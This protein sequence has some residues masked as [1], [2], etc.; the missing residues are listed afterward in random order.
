MSRSLPEVAGAASDGA[1]L[2]VVVTDADGTNGMASFVEPADGTPAN[3]GLVSLAGGNGRRVSHAWFDGKSFLVG[4]NDVPDGSAFATLSVRRFSTPSTPV[5]DTG[6]V[7]EPRAIS[8]FPDPVAAGDGR[9]RSLFVY[10]QDDPAHVGDAIKARLIKTD[11]SPADAGD[12]DASDG[13]GGMGAIDAGDG[14]PEARP[15]GG[16]GAM[17]S[18]PDATGGSAGSTAAGG[19]GGVAGSAGEAGSV[20]G[21][22]A[23]GTS[24]SGGTAGAGA[25]PGGTGALGGSGPRDAAAGTAGAAGTANQAAPA[26]DEGGC[27][28]HLASRTE[29]R[30][31]WVVL[32]ALGAA[33]A[34]SRRVRRRRCP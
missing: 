5:D 13:T 11:E 20:G 1:R 32:G 27:G 23:G 8:P 12:G 19:S 3:P 7:V 31:S 30:L 24:A 17:D 21:A 18:A 9:G 14:A 22:A 16:S 29:P 6:T 34:H 15:T 25:A 10:V 33:L 2:F 28:C 4:F 26:T